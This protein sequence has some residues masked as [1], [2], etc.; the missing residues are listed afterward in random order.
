MNS[1]KEKRLRTLVTFNRIT[2]FAAKLFGMISK[3]KDGENVCLIFD[4]GRKFQVTSN[5][6]IE[7]KIQ[8]VYFNENTGKICETTIE[9]KYLT[10]SYVEGERLEKL[11]KNSPDGLAGIM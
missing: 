4:K 11:I 6:I 5:I 9:P 8:V 10:Y 7:G 3:F 1:I 2:K